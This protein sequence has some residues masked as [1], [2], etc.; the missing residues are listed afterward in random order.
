MKQRIFKLFTII[1]AITVA[2]LALTC[3]TASLK[4][5]TG[6]SVPRKV[7]LELHLE[8]PLGETAGDPVAK[9]LGRE[10]PTMLSI[11]TALERA[12][13]DDRVVGLVAYVGE[14]GHGMARTQEL[15]DAITRFRESGKFAIAY[16]ETFGEL[17]PGNQGYYLATAFD[18][19]WLQPTGGVGLT[20]LRAEA[21]FVKG[22]LDL[23]EVQPRG[24]HR[25]EYKNAFNMFTETA[26]TPAHREAM[27]AII[28]DMFGQMVAAIADRRGIS[29][30]EVR[31]LVDRGPFLGPEALEAKL[32]DGLA[33]HDEVLAKVKERAEGAELL[34][35]AKYHERAGGAW[36]KG[37]SKIA[38]VYG[39]GGVARG[40]SSTDPLMGDQTM[41]ATTV[42]GAL[43]A[44]IA[45]EDVKAIVFRVDSPGGSAVA[46]DTIWREVDRA[47]KAG[48]PVIVSMG[49]VAG[50]GGYYVACSA[51][52]IV[53]HPGTITGSIGVLG[54]KPVTQ[55]AWNKVGV[56][57]DA[58]E[59]SKNAAMFSD[60]TDY[61]AE[62]WARLQAWL[63]WV[64][65]DFKKRV[66]EGRGLDDD[67]VEAVAKGRIWT[68][69][70]AKGLGLV[71]ELGGFATA[72]ALA[73]SEAG[74]DADEDIE[75]ALYP[76]ERGIVEQFLGPGPDS[77]ESQPKAAEV[78]IA[79]DIER[80]R[81]LVRQLAVLTDP[82]QAVLSMQPLEIGH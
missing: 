45:D 59:T 1:G 29:E 77:S 78:R 16:A 60:L 5:M 51:N 32:V 50:S 41:G 26:Y 74:I 7:V 38:L 25:R 47:K 28:D 3:V 70:R 82:D 31:S 34:Y 8:R 12:S 48:K 52:K 55:K 20:G 36:D 54:G 44:A 13:K 62:E 75:L 76:R 35:L 2:L 6:D 4:C 79:A 24:D 22:T 10:A 9:I 39:V 63:D 46:S 15:R 33:Y 42:A 56:T 69:E 37:G 68:G 73:K 57:W 61:D 80:L 53:A 18:E 72:I 17:S 23:V 11:V 49:N 43:R 64:Y 40:E 58:V 65:V 27:K 67:A 21:M 19:V 81:P 14:G 30:D 71:D 66:G